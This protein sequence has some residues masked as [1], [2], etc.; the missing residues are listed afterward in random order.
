ME[1]AFVNKNDQRYQGLF[2]PEYTHAGHEVGHAHL[3]KTAQ[4]S[5]DQAGT[6][7]VLLVSAQDYLRICTIC[8]TQQKIELA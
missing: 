8:G 1:G 4:H 3:L 5:A 7:E 6:F 2:M